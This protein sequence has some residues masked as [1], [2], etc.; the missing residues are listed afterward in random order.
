MRKTCERLVWDYVG[1]VLGK[2]RL[3]KHFIFVLRYHELLKS[4]KNGHFAKALVRENGQ[5]R[6]QISKCQKPTKMYSKITELL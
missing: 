5:F 2:E 4:G 6:G 1:V 3:Q